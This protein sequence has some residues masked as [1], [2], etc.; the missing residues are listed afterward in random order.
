[1]T[2]EVLNIFLAQSRMAMMMRMVVQY[3][4]KQ[5]GK[6]LCPCESRNEIVDNTALSRCINFGDAQKEEV[7][8]S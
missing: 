2:I 4:S 8:A 5:V 1:M 6:N 7:M 3:M